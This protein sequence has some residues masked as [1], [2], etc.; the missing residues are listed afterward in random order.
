MSTILP[1]HRSCP[2]NMADI[3]SLTL[4]SAMTFKV[5][6]AMVTLWCCTDKECPCHDEDDLEPEDRDS[7]DC[8]DCGWVHRPDESC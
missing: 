5:G 2:T 7:W 8:P 3:D 4:G 6:L 1:T